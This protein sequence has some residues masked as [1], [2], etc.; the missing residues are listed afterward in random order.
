MGGRMSSDSQGRRWVSGSAGKA[1]MSVICGWLIIGCAAVDVRPAPRTGQPA[2]PVPASLEASRIL[3]LSGREV[4]RRT[5]AECQELQAEERRAASPVSRVLNL[6]TIDY[7]PAE[8]TLDLVEG[9]L[10]GARYRYRVEPSYRGEYFT[11][12]DRYRFSSRV[13]PGELLGRT[14]IKV[15]FARGSEV[16]FA[17]QFASGPE[18][19]DPA[20]GYLPDRIPFSS[21]IARSLK[22]GDYVRF[23]ARMGL[24]AN[25]GQVWPLAGYLLTAATQYS[26]VLS[27]EYQVHVFR[28]D[29]DRVRLRLVGERAR[30][31]SL[32]ASAGAS[33]LLK[34]ALLNR[35]R[36][37]LQPLV[38]LLG[39]DA[40]AALAAERSSSDLFMADYTMDLADPEAA[41]AYDQIFAG[42]R[43]LASVRIARPLRNSFDLR[44]Q[45]IGTVEAVDALARADLEAE[46]PRVT[47]HF[48]GANYSR[49][50]KLQFR[51]RL[52]SF[53]VDRS[54]VFRRNLITRAELRPEGGESLTHYLLPNWAQLRD[55][56]MLFGMLDESHARS[57]DALFLADAEGRPQQFLNIGFGLTYRDRRLRPSEYRRLRRRLELLLPQGAEAE[58]AQQM[59]DTQWLEDRFRRNFSLDLNYFF[60]ESAFDGL[61]AAGFGKE[62]RLRNALADFIV[63]G[64]AEGE[65]P[66]Y[67]G[68]VDALVGRELEAR[69][70]R[71][72]STQQQSR[73]AAYQAWQK[74]ID[75]TAAGLATAFTAGNNNTRRMEAILALRN[76][77]FYRQVGTAF[78]ADLVRVAGLDLAQV[79]FL[80]F[81]LNADGHQGV[82][83]E[84]GVPGERA[85]YD[86]VKFIQ[87][88]LN[89]RSLDLRELGD[90]ESVISR[91][92]LVVN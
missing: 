78:W 43:Q 13:R 72:L 77:G 67:R 66:Y 76:S 83:Y 41:A 6:A 82:H 44:D 48:K 4:L 47:R 51:M 56:S 85:L 3:C 54:R 16:L 59:G 71:G 12:L 63:R 7:A 87:N 61:V 73:Q 21:A 70:R 37:E 75:Q 20:N 64:I 91:T 25:A 40:K 52:S 15:G 17:Q 22:P 84:F 81:T 42:E 27:G 32:S 60:R 69:V 74:E 29:G 33:R 88:L 58:I 34:A 92:T 50:Q 5:A 11:R 90:L 19:R 65:F 9:I 57:A 45:L 24:T 86:S 36:G 26:V 23:D 14:P 79:M 35:V 31:A 49:S 1:V 53:D 68:S 39:L 10:I 2:Q 18:A 89:D 30:D 80:E 38:Q 55:R 8:L 28:L 46:A 62:S